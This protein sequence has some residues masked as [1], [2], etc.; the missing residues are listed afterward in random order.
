MP[1]PAET[2]E[3]AYT[4]RR[5]RHAAAA[6]AFD[7]RFDLL[8]NARLGLFAAFATALLAA[9]VWRLP[10]APLALPPALGFAAALVAHERCRRARARAEAARDLYAD[11]LSRLAGQWQGRGD[12]G[13]DLAPADHPYAADLD[14][15]GRGGLFEYISAARTPAGRHTLAAWLAEPADA[16]AVRARQ[17]AIVELAPRL[18]LREDL[19][20]VGAE[21]AA[22]VR[23]ESLAAWVRRPVHPRRGALRAAA[24]AAAAINAALCAAAIALGA[25]ALF[26]A[27]VLI[28][29]AAFAAAAGLVRGEMAALA[30]PAREWP[31]LAAALERLEREP[32][33][34]PLLRALRAELG[35]DRA[36]ASRALRALERTVWR[37]EQM[38][39]PMLAIPLGILLWGPIG[40]L[41]IQAWRAR[42]ADDLPRWL[43]ALGA[44]EALASL[45]R[46]AYEHPGFVFPDLETGPARFE[47][48]A[49]GHPLIPGAAR[50]C[51]DAALGPECAILLVSGSNMS[52]K[53]TFLR[54][55]GVNAVLAL[56]GAP[57][58][59]ARL[60]LTPLR[61]GATMHVQDSVQDG[62]SRFYA[63]L[64]RVKRLVDAP[65]EPPVLFLLDELL[66]GTNSRDRLAGAEALLGRLLR[67]GG[68]GLATTHDLAL[69][70][71]ADTLPAPARNAHFV[72]DFADGALRFDYRLRPGVVQHSNAL[73]LMASLG[74]ICDA[75]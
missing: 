11:G 1:S 49:L 57:V 9:Q 66:H 29:T 26:L 37:F 65:P 5:A 74:L 21:V 13:V 38:R 61:V 44:L 59:A 56:A 45:A 69:T 40:A 35:P 43:D 42:H 16:D 6:A 10:P 64:R 7:R 30:E 22:H 73:Q 36:T 54:S 12:A 55:V 60:R 15:F 58:C 8:A 34:A 3:Q 20:R 53:S 71:L 70:R 31:A 41:A 17:R 39:N 25:P 51:N 33:E 2:P 67:R 32:V 48:E 47:A 4:A 72:D 18:E 24:L 28:G 52:G 19:A 68:I 14:F 46:F 50:I 27:A 62:A 23:P 63:E 75:T